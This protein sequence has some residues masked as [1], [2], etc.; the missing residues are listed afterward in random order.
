M[1]FH[2]RRRDHWMRMLLMQEQKVLPS[3]KRNVRPAAKKTKEIAALH[4]EALMHA[5]EVLRPRDL[6]WPGSILHPSDLEIV[7]FLEELGTWL[8]L[9]DQLGGEKDGM[10]AKL[11]LL[12]EVRI[13]AKIHLT[14]R[15]PMR[16][17]MY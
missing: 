17:A 2:R 16:P 12:L 7:T 5:R 15:M 11:S 13:Q 1:H 4:Q 9:L 8:A 14:H 6:E 10:L 3:L